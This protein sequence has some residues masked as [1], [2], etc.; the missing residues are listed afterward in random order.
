MKP[1]PRALLAALGAALL[2]AACSSAPRDRGPGEE[3]GM[4]DVAETQLAHG[5]RQADRGNLA[6]ALALL[7]EAVRFAVLADD[8]GLRARAG[9]SRA[10][11]L[12]SLGHA[13]RAE[14]GWAEAYAEAQRSGNRE[15]IALSRVH[16]ARG[17]LLSAIGGGADGAGE[18]AQSVLDEVA[19]EMGALR[20]P[21]HE[22]FAWT[23]RGRAEGELRRFAEAEAALRRSLAIHER[24]Q[25]F[26]LA[27]FDWFMIASF[28]SRA[29]D[30]AGA[31]QALESSMALDR[32]V[33]NS[34][35]LAW[36]WRALGDIE[37]RAGNAEAA[38][39]AYRRAADIF[40]AMG[41]HEAAED[42]L[43]RAG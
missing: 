7:D 6:D 18:V 41:Q 8:S 19:G 16:I 10:N 17:R 43:A 21:L 34:W 33:E 29:G 28:R 1:G 15:L 40:R 12:L 11:V 24:T 13:D 2:A 3:F 30:V 36:S 31:R 23:V 38:S 27:A 14:A 20:A 26:E 22:A 42:A 5:N 35:G 9:L 39:A 37:A 4:R 32:R 25:H